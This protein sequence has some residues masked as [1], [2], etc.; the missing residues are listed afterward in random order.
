MR[1]KVTDL[2]VEL[3]GTVLK[4]TDDFITLWNL[5]S[6]LSVFWRGF[7]QQRRCIMDC[8]AFRTA[9]SDDVLVAAK[10]L[11]KRCPFIILDVEDDHGNVAGVCHFMIDAD[12]TRFGDWEKLEDGSPTP[13]WVSTCGCGSKV[14]P[15]ER[16][17][18]LQALYETYPTEGSSA[19]TDL[20]WNEAMRLNRDLLLVE[21]AGHFMKHWYVHSTSSHTSRARIGQTTHLIH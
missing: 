16:K 12:D 4:E 18:D 11:T 8:V 2:P 13:R 7:K 9:G 10:H 1:R 15:T 21:A 3:I 17:I 5:V 6:G 20:T 19:T 14:N